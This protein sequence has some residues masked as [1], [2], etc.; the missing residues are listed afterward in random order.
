MTS[1]GARAVLK[2]TIWPDFHLVRGH[3]FAHFSFWIVE[4]FCIQLIVFLQTLLGRIDQT[5][6]R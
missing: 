5:Q 1:S 2:Q 3:D 6:Y 4:K